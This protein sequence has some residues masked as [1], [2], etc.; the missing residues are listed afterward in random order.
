MNLKY[1]GY[2][3]EFKVYIVSLE[4]LLTIPSCLEKKIV[5]QKVV[6]VNVTQVN[7]GLISDRLLCFS[8]I[9]SHQS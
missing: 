9:Q 5:V 8:K 4:T 3:C 1:I 6:N 7:L 2:R